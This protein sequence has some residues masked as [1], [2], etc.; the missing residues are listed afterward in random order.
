MCV[1]VCVRGRD[2][3]QINFFLVFHEFGL[4]QYVY[5]EILF[6]QTGPRYVGGSFEFRVFLVLDMLLTATETSQWINIQK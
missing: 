6:S 1:C 5:I 2:L 3:H 4:F